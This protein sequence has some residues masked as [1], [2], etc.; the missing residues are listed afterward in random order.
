MLQVLS[1]VLVS[2]PHYMYS[3]LL[4]L[5]DLQMSLRRQYDVLVDYSTHITND[6]PTLRSLVATFVLDEC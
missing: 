3:S 2:L 5:R 4:I 1:L 6:P